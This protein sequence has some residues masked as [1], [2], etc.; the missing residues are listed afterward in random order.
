MTD[1]NHSA[2]YLRASLHRAI[3]QG[4]R[5]MTV[6]TLDL[7]DTL[8]ELERLQTQQDLNR[9]EAPI[10]G[11]ADPDAIQQMRQGKL[12]SMTV[13]RKKVAAR[14]QQICALTIKTIAHTQR[15]AV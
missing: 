2:T 12:W 7:K 9:P 5:S 15:A 14:T 4:D 11:W 3:N 8:A 13:T 10:V 6:S 1:N